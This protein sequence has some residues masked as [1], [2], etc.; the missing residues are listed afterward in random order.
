MLR[1]F[2][3][4]ACLFGCQ[5]IEAQSP[6]I[7]VDIAEPEPQLQTI[8]LTDTKAKVAQVMLDVAITN[9]A[10]V[11]FAA[12]LR[13]LPSD[14]DYV[15]L[16][17]DSPGGLLGAAREISRIIESHP[18]RLVCLVDGLAA[19]GAYY[20]LQSCQMRLMTHRSNLMLHEA[21][22]ASNVD[23]AT[24]NDREA[25]RAINLAMSYQQCHRLKMKLDDCRARYSGR[26]WW[27]TA[28]KALEAG[29]VDGVVDTPMQLMGVLG[30]NPPPKQ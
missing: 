18:Q 7:E 21:F 9:E 25:L 19:S 2:I 27:L 6:P 12:T 28:D 13:S 1:L 4:I 29:A 17:I 14:L 8:L 22:S 16:V 5:P 20:L 23:S 30:E 26:E 15:V 11:A 3:V 24:E 10:A